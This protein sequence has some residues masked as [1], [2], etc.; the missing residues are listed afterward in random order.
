MKKKKRYIFAGVLLVLLVMVCYGMTADKREMK[1]TLGMDV[2]KGELVTD[3][4]THGG[5][6]NDGMIYQ[7]RRFDEDMEIP[8]GNGWHSLPLSQNMKTLLYGH[9]EGNSTV[10]PFIRD[11]EEVPSLPVIENGSYFFLDRHSE[12][13]DPYDDAELF[14]RSSFN[15][16]VALYD[17][18]AQRLYYIELD[19]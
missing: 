11:G 15:L 10:G 5:L 8:T 4:D 7:V 19:T 14:H 6:P 3:I 9:T 16:T 1:R 2:S 12:S 13:T 18:D 17:A